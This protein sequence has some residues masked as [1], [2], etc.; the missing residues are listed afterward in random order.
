MLP[1]FRI[2]KGLQSIL[3]V[4]IIISQGPG[5]VSLTNA[6]PSLVRVA[7]PKSGRVKFEALGPAG[8]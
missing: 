2:P 5:K 8:S 6:R 1:V 7:P 4:N 3:N